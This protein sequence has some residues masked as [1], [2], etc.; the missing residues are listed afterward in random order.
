MT[1]HCHAAGRLVLGSRQMRRRPH[2]YASKGDFE[3]RRY[4][5]ADVSPRMR[6]AV[7]NGSHAGQHLLDLLLK[8]KY[9]ERLD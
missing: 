5:R 3:Q 9:Q 7:R 8:Q 4:A 2:L 1:L 6:S